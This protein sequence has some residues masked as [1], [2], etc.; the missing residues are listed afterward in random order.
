MRFIVEDTQNNILTRDLIVQDPK[1]TRTLSG[2]CTIAFTLLPD[3]QEASG[4]TWKAWGQWVHVEIDRQ[5]GTRWI[6]ASGLVQPSSWDQESGSISITATGFSGYPEGIPWLENWNPFTIDPF[7]VVH[8]IWNHIQSYPQGNLGVQI[9]PASSNTL[10]LPGFYFDGSE[11]N[12]D[13][14]AYFVRAED[15]RDCQ[16]EL[17]SL[18]RDLPIDF[19]EQSYWSTDKTIIT[20]KIELAYPRRGVRHTG[21]AFRL[22]EN[23]TTG[24]VVPEVEMDWVSD[25][26]VRGWWPGRMHSSTFSNAD[27]Y[28][29]RRVIRDED[30]LINSKERSAVWAK[31]KLARRQV[32][33]HWNSITVDMYHSNA[34]WGTYDVGD[35]IL[36]SGSIPYVGNVSEWHRIMT[37]EPNDT[38]GEVIMTTKHVDAFNLDAIDFPPQ[39][40]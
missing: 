34:P 14:F 27:P 18:Y 21:I 6:I 2:P 36:I 8:K 37:I 17:T 38:L 10:M 11:F 3:E 16:E 15:Y 4:I 28:R 23:M 29:Y 19:V 20:K 31:R 26:I 30:A 5:D 35:D 24:S 9:T 12:I 1:V 32:P 39:G 22:G 7:H 33:K 40:G 25:I 13:F